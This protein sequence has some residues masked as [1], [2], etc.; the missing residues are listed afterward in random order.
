[1]RSEKQKIIDILLEN[2]YGVYCDTCK[3][4]DTNSCDECHRKYMNWALSINTARTLAEEIIEAI[5][6]E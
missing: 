6:N 1:M 5:T 4:Y 2:F 3:Y